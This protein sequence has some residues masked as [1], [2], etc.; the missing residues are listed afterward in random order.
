MLLSG[1]SIGSCI[2][3]GRTFKLPQLVSNVTVS[4]S[5]FAGKRCAHN[6]RNCARLGTQRADPATGEGLLIRSGVACSSE[7]SMCLGEET[8]MRVV[9]L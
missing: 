2:Q 3:T 8:T 4:K 5:V 7:R 9:G 1:I 6:W